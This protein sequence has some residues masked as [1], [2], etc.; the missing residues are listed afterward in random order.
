MFGLMWWLRE[1]VIVNEEVWDEIEHVDRALVV[2][3]WE[4]EAS[5]GW[6]SLI[7]SYSGCLQVSGNV[8]NNCDELLSNCKR[9]LP[10]LCTSN[11][12]SGI[13]VICIF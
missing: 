2:K 7:N 6:A 5:C 3:T 1:I 10:R 4:S 8:T 12:V 9:E 13:D 11:S